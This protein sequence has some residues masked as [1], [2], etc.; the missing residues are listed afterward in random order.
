[1]ALV[2]PGGV[3][4]EN[5]K[6]NGL[7]NFLAKAWTRG[8]QTHSAQDIYKLI[9]AQGGNIKGFSG[10]NTFGL[11]ADFLSK[12]LD[13]SLALFTEILLT[14][15]FPSAEVKKLCP[16]ILAQL[17]SQ[18]DDLPRVAVKEFRR[19][20][21]SPHPYSMNPL[22]KA[23]VIESIASKD[24]FDAYKNFVIPDRG[25]LSIVGNV[26][27]EEIISNIETRFSAWSVK[28]SI[29]LSTPPPPDSLLSPKILT[30]DKEKQQTHT[31]LGFSG[32]T[33][34]SPDRYATQTLNAVLS[35]QGGRLFTNLRGKEGL[36][37]SVTSF[38]G[39]GLDYGCF[40]FYIA[41]SPEK[42]DRALKSLWREIYRITNEPIAEDEL[43][44]AKKWLIGTHEIGLQ[45]NRAKAM[46]MALNELYGLGYNF[47][48]EFV[49]KIEE[50]TANQILNVAKKTIDSQRYVLVRVGP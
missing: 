6:N 4:Y 15:T 36:A 12:N 32:T 38:L 46:D 20:L 48:S 37:Y 41:C 22:G 16:L 34:Y 21:F 14:P 17:K 9:E 39:L 18:A 29:P 10:Q 19:L 1:L 33:L 25:V 27:A 35:G 30:L 47:S 43:E 5:E 44:R 8:T 11:Q 24:L 49:R 2:F 3:R 45:T 26:N 28:S 42:K 23:S 50:V 31:V 7:F 13:R 40:A